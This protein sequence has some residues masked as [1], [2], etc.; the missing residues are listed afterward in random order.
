MKRSALVT[1][2]FCAFVI[3]CKSDVA[4]CAHCGMK[5]DPTSPWNAEIADGTNITHFDTPRCAL[6]TW[7]GSGKHGSV[8]VRDYYDRKMKSANELHFVDGSDVIGPM[9]PEL[10][11]V[12]AARIAKFEK[13]HGGTEK[14]ELP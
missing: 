9:G 1:A 10:V 8:R 7:S 12:D 2:F 13:D 6:A 4:R 3:A 5:I 14:M 11:P